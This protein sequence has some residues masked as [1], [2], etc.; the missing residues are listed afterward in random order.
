M[1]FIVSPR[2]Q[3]LMPGM[4]VVLYIVGTIVFFLSS[5]CLPSNDDSVTSEILGNNSKAATL[6]SKQMLLRGGQFVLKERQQALVLTEE[7]DASI[8]KLISTVAFMDDE[9][10]RTLGI[11][12]LLAMGPKILPQLFSGLENTSGTGRSAVLK[13]VEGLA[14]NTSPKDGKQQNV[15]GPSLIKT[16]NEPTFGDTVIGLLDRLGRAGTIVVADDHN[17]ETFRS[18]VLGAPLVHVLTNS[19]EEAAKLAR[20]KELMDCDRIICAGG[21][22]VLDVCKAVAIAGKE[23]VILPTILSSAACIG[24]NRAVLGIGNESF[25]GATPKEVVYNI[26]ALAGD[27][28]EVLYSWTRAGISEYLVGIPATMDTQYRR[29]QTCGGNG[30]DLKT[31][32]ADNPATKQVFDAL[33]WFTTSFTGEFHHESL[34]AL[35]EYF[36]H[37]A[38]TDIANGNNAY[39]KGGEHHF[40]N[41]LMKLDP[42]LR[43]SGPAHGDIVAIGNLMTARVYAEHEGDDLLYRVLS[44]IFH[45]MGVPLSYGAL[46]KK[47]LTRNLMVQAMT[48]IKNP[49]YRQS[50]LADCVETHDTSVLD[51]ILG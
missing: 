31:V 16:H 40:Y 1:R 30:M 32:I 42:S 4:I 2:F 15:R 33:G 38:L 13:A 14:R 25:L 49:S 8:D 46:E 27:D 21:H 34:T 44:S 35:V 9:E 11:E 36:H 29:M 22:A 26:D 7:T 43:N 5:S 23:L 10:T 47:G 50:L 20:S 37:E 19:H 39:R 24:N 6:L 48:D 18:L 41:A 3:H 51:E 12:Q 28:P 17:Y 45:K